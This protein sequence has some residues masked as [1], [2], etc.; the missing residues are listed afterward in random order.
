[1]SPVLLVDAALNLIQSVSAQSAPETIRVQLQP[2]PSARILQIVLSI[3]VAAVTVATFAIGYWKR[4]RERLAAWYQKV[5]VDA[6][7]PK[8]FDFFEKVET[9][10]ANAAAEC[11]RCRSQSR[12]T[13]SNKVTAAIAAFSDDLIQVKDFVARRLVVFDEADT[14]KFQSRMLQ[15]QDDISEWFEK[16]AVKGRGNPEVIHGILL[17]AQRE[18]VRLL[19]ESE[20]ANF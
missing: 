8:I 15:L 1:M 5:V 13:L 20:F 3:A 18:I 10:L 2:D 4:I 7:L 11:A 16:F 17:S 12:K 6:C 14:S 9:D 19:Y